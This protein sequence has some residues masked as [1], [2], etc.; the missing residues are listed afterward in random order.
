MLSRPDQVIE[1]LPVGHMVPLLLSSGMTVWQLRSRTKTRRAFMPG[2]EATPRK[3]GLIANQ[4]RVQP[5]LLDRSAIYGRRASKLEHLCIR[6]P[7]GINAPAM[8]RRP[9]NGA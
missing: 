6:D 8:K 7:P 3:R 9:V 4:N 2:Y 5:A 1:K